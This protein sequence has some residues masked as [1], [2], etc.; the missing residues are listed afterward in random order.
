VELVLAGPP[1]SGKSAVGRLIATRHGVP[2]VD[3]DDAIE[4]AAGRPISAIFEAEGEAGFRARERAAIEGLAPPRPPRGGGTTAGGGTAAG[5]AA[6]GGA[7]ADGGHAPGR[8]TSIE[9]VIAVGGGA[10]VDPRNRWLLFRGR[11]VVTLWATPGV[12][13]RR[14]RG[15]PVR[16][17]LAG[18]DPVAMLSDLLARRERWYAAGER[19]D[20]TGPLRSV[21]RRLEELLASPP[22]P[23]TSLLRADTMTGRL[24]IGDGDALP[25]LM[26]ALASLGARRVAIVSE[27]A[28]W[29]LHG[30][31]LAAGLAAAGLDVVPLM[32]PGGEA[33]K[34]V[35]AYARLVRAMASARLERGDPV[36]AIGG[37]ALGDAA[38]FA[39]ATYLRGV[40]LVHVPT[41]LVAQI[42]SAIGGKTAIDIPEGK[43]LVG[44]FHQPRAVVED[45]SILRT[46]PARQRRAALGEAIKYGAL[47]DERLL[48]LLERD[49]GAI[50]RG[51]RQAFESGALAELVERCAWAKVEVVAAD[52]RE[53][54]GRLVLNLGH[55]I[56]HAIEAAAGYRRILHGEAVAHGLRG[57]LAVG[58]AL[59]LTPP[60]RAARIERLL[61]AAGLAQEPPGVDE[62]AVRAHLALDKKHAA[63]RLRWVLPTESGVVVRSDVPD[64]AVTAGIAAALRGTP[65]GGSGPGDRERAA[66]ASAW[67]EGPADAAAGAGAGSAPGAPR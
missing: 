39:A 26:E 58:L 5:G 66:S 3:L 18:R 62:A 44:A 45:V 27:P 12:L 13:M 2:F 46:L 41:T 52:E 42:D 37:G 50:A 33:A 57:A 22:S 8:V 67:P 65:V 55:S 49:A 61:A 56:G 28:A 25:R 38:G 21:A 59:G 60:E 35:A 51:A 53:Q 24:T 6:S 20:A 48:D 32:V 17:L 30:E 4:A 34:T 47:G 7:T 15:G 11:R 54:A 63:G 10:V 43:N 29:R 40:P 9:R 64:E 36:V 14:L 19:V 23:G 16:P 31:R 1:G